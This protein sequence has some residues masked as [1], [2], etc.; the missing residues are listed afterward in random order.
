MT[1][2]RKIGVDL[3]MICK[4]ASITATS[5]M[6]YVPFVNDTWYKNSFIYFFSAEVF[7]PNWYKNLAF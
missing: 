5:I 1:E 4:P 3:W 7:D 2:K 6:G